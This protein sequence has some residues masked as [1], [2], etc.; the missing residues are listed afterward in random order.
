MLVLAAVAGAAWWWCIGRPVVLPDAPSARVACVS[1]APFRQPGE[2]PF[3]VNTF[4]SPERI[5]ADLRALS[6][7]SIA[8]VRIRKHMV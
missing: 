7:V 2:T 3:D 8:C 4:V 6:S 1:Y 5:D